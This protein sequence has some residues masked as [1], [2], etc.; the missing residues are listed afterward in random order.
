[1]RLFKS[2]KPGVNPAKLRETRSPGV[3][4]LAFFPGQ[5]LVLNLNGHGY[6]AY[7]CDLRGNILNLEKDVEIALEQ[8][9]MFIKQVIGGGDTFSVVLVGDRYGLLHEIYLQPFNQSHA[10]SA[11]KDPEHV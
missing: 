5:L 4:S 6:H 3:K 1:M 8:P 2:S 11:N 9:V 10:G 7:L